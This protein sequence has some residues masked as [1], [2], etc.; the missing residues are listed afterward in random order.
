MR[1]LGHACG[2]AARGLGRRQVGPGAA[3]LSTSGRRADA[4]AAGGRRPGVDRAR[5]PDELVASPPATLAGK[6]EVR[7]IGI[8]EVPYVAEAQLVLV[9]DL[10]AEKEVPRMPPEPFETVTI[11]GVAVPRL[12]LAPFE[13]S[14]ALK[15]KL[16]LLWAA[17]QRAVGMHRIGLACGLTR[18]VK[19]AA[20][21]RDAFWAATAGGR[22]T[23]PGHDRTCPRHPRQACRGVPRRPRACGRPADA[24]RDHLD[25]TRRRRRATASGHPRR[26]RQ[27]ELRRR[28]DPAHRHVRRH[29]LQPRH[30]GHG[31]RARSR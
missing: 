12:H 18:L 15:L 14:A 5:G 9:V 23:E 2:A 17:S 26:R 24:D 8:V 16:A 31:G 25:R 4:A 1:R 19:I 30:L 6:I 27:G 3:L 11:A 28:R 22:N 29:A 7:G 21:G 20:L 10:V 13:L